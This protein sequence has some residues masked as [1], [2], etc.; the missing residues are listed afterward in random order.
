MASLQYLG[1]VHAFVLG[2]WLFGDPV[3]GLSIVGTLLIVLAGVTAS[4]L[5]NTIRD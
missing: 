2:V 5:G 3:H 4:R 1:I